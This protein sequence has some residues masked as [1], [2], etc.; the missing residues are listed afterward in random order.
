[1][2]TAI[3]ERDIRPAAICLGIAGVDR[4]QDAQAVRDI[5][6]RIGFK[7]RTLVVNDAFVALVAG[8]GDAPGVALIAGTGSIAYGR[9]GDG[10]AARAG[11]WGYLLGDEGS[12]FWIGRTALAAIVRQADGRGPATLLT[13]LVLRHLNLATA[14]DLVYEIYYH[15][16]QRHTIAT[17][18]TLVQQA[19]DNGDAVAAE[20]LNRASTELM[21]AASSVISRL[22]M[23]GDAF[24]LVLAG[25]IFKVVPWLAEEVARQSLEIAPRSRVDVLKVEPAVGA[26][27]LA[28]AEAHGGAALP[29]YV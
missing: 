26:V 21:V 16:V 12:G 23:R 10:R 18:A 17:L 29:S 25:G 2:D 1:M 20:I 5:M 28:V 9:N 11:G 8:A 15:D 14:D 24:P 27:R 13:D 4:P 6:R 22:G 19:R 7:T 3:G